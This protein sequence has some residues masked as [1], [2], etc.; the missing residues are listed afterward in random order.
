M[1]KGYCVDCDKFVDYDIKEEVRKITVLDVEVE[2]TTKSAICKK[3]G[4]LVSAYD[5]EVWNDISVFDEYK[6]KVGLMT[7]KELV[8]NRERLGMNQEDFAK[9]LGFSL[10]DVQRY[11]HGKIQTKEIDELFKSKLLEAK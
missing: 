3:C 1:E 5:V 10:K 4:V 7:T 11:E 9:Y 8:A 2:A 6:K